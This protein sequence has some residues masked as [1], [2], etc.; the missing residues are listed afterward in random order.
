MDGGQGAPR[1]CRADAGLAVR[2]SGVLLAILAATATP[3]VAQPQPDAPGQRFEIL[4]RDLPKPYAT[5]SAGNSPETVRREAGMR[6]RVPKGY[7][8]N[9]FA[10]GLEH[11]SEEHT[12]ELQSLMRNSYAG[13][14]LQ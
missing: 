5:E 7:R 13:F 4:P 11:R 12:S 1:R 8:V 10:E 14:C 6:P 3:V 9:I 2:T